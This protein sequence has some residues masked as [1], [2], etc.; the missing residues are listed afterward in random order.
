MRTLLLIAALLLPGA[1]QAHD[2]GVNLYILSG[3]SNMARFPAK[4][5]KREIHRE[6][7]TNH[8]IFVKH[9]KGGQPIARW[10]ETL[11]GDIYTAMM[12]RVNKAIEGKNITSVTLIWHHG[13]ADAMLN[14]S[15]TYLQSFDNLLF[16][17][18]RDLGRND[19]KLVVARIND[20]G[21][22]QEWQNIRDIQEY[23]GDTYPNAAWINTDDLNGA[24]NDL[25]TVAHKQ[26]E[27][28]RRYAEAAQ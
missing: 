22:G 12:S 27:L 3:Q 9:A 2:Q 11:N 28:A 14:R 8:T 18:E 17:L 7:G 16:Q 1:I 21:K 23:I 26:G 15:D 4:L 24:L 6:L 19:I 13:E 20:W 10:D 25:H 5:F